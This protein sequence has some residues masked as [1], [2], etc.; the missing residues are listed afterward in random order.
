MMMARRR[1]GLIFAPS[2]KSGAQGRIA[3]LPTLL[4]YSL[5]ITPTSVLQKPHSAGRDL[6]HA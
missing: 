2:C 6:G 3:N 4:Q 1:P 5:D